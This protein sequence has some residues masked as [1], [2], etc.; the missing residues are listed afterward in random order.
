[1]L[2]P[3]YKR[4]RTNQKNPLMLLRLKMLHSVQK[5]S[6]NFLPTL[7]YF[8]LKLGLFSMTESWFETKIKVLIINFLNAVFCHFQMKCLP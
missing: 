6:F 2:M 8:F 5:W 7:K 4:N 3:L 1:M